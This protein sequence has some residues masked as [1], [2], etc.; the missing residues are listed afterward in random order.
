M[1]RFRKKI[2]KIVNFFYA[3]HRLINKC[4]VKASDRLGLNLGKPYVGIDIG[5]YLDATKSASTVF[6]L[7]YIR[8]ICAWG[9]AGGIYSFVLM[10]KG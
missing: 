4:I 7:G 9:G 1:L 10:I 8:L 5:A 2:K 3:L 6:L